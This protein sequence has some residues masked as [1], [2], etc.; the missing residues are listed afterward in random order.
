VL[1]PLITAC[2]GP[3]STAIVT[4]EVEVCFVTKLVTDMDTEYVFNGVSA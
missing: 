2:S 3:C 1:P 4:E